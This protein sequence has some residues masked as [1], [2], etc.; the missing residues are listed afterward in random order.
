MADR[1][2]ST[3]ILY[4]ATGPRYVEEAERS[5]ESVRCHMPGVSAVLWTDC[6]SGLQ[7]SL[8]QDINSISNPT[9]SFFDKI[10]PLCSTPFDKTIFLDTDTIVVA[11]ISDLFQ[12]LD[13]TQLAFAHG[14]VRA[15]PSF[16]IDDVP[17]SFSE[18][19]TG[20]MAYRSDREVKSFFR[21]WAREYVKQLEMPSPPAHDQ[22]AFRR[23]L[24]QSSLSYTVLPSEYNL[25]TIFPMFIGGNSEPKVLHGRGRSLNRAIRGTKQYRGKVFLADYSRSSLPVRLFDKFFGKSRT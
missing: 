14:P 25:R 20:V 9:R 13:R 12:L 7:E 10:D 2:E 21:A 1:I 8:F 4:V 19:N 18:P 22:P 11:D 5:L 16:V 15:S 6:P 3:G 24:F 17:K 23:V